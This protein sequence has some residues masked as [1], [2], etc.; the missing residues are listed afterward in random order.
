MKNDTNNNGKKYLPNKDRILWLEYAFECEFGSSEDLEGL[1]V[2]WIPEWIAQQLLEFDLIVLNSHNG[3]N[4]LPSTPY[5][6]L[7]AWGERIVDLYR[8]AN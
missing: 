3:R 4:G 7:T 1:P 8:D 2:D 6:T 5:F